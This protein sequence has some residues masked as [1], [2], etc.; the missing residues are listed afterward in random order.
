MLDHFVQIEYHHHYLCYA[1][2]SLIMEGECSLTEIDPC[3]IIILARLRLPSSSEWIFTI[4][5]RP[6]DQSLNFQFL[7]REVWNIWVESVS[8]DVEM[9]GLI[10]VWCVATQGRTSHSNCHLAWGRGVMAKTWH[11]VLISWGIWTF[12]DHPWVSWLYFPFSFLMMNLDWC[13]PGP[14]ATHSPLNH[15][16]G[17]NIQN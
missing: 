6:Q 17:Y 4:S 1:R 7:M 3:T 10:A 13:T 9:S 12:W 2:T 5:H 8:K 15:R 11:S 14:P 16:D